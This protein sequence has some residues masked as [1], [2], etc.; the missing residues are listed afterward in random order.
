M[1]IRRNIRSWGSEMQ[2]RHL[3]ERETLQ[4]ERLKNY[5]KEK[6]M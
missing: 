2:W 5:K 4:A 1:G 6:S 3:F